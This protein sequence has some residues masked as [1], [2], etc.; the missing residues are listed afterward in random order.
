[1]RG[2]P[3]LRAQRTLPTSGQTDTV[4]VRPERAGRILAKST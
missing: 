2:S 3:M 1:M 4:E